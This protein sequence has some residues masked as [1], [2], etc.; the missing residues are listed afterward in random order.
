MPTYIRVKDLPNSA[1]SLNADDYIMLSGSVGGARKILK[2]DFLNTV[3]DEFEASP[4]TYKLATLD[5]SNKLN[6]EQL[7]ASAFSYQGTWAASTNTPTLANG[8][9]TAGHVYYASDSGS[10]NFGAGSI[11]FSTGDAVVYDGSIWQKVPDV[12]NI[13][14]GKGTVDEGKTTLEIPNVGTAANEVPTNGQLGDLAFQSSA[15]V[16]VDDLTVD[17]QLTAAVGKPMPVNGPTM[18]FD[19]VNDY[20]EF[21]DNDAFSFTNGTDDTPF[22]VS[23]WVKMEDATNFPV[24]SKYNTTTATREWLFYVSG[25]DYLGSVLMGSDGNAASVVSDEVITNRE[26]KW[27]HLAMTYAG[28]GPNS[29]NS[30]SSASASGNFE[31]YI[32]GKLQSNVTRSSAS[33]V[34]MQSTSQ[35]VELAR[36]NNGTEAKGE[37]RDVKLFNKELSAAEVREVYSNG[38][39]PESFAESTG[40][41]EIYTGDSSNFAGGIGNWTEEGSTSL[42]VAASG[43]E[44]LITNTAGASGGTKGARNLTD[45]VTEGKKLRLRFTARCSSGTAAGMTVKMFNG[46]TA[47]SAIK[48]QGSGTASSGSSAV[49]S[50]TPTG[51]NETHIVEFVLAGSA[52][53]KL[54]FNIS[55][56][57]TGEVYNF[58]NITLTQI[59]SVLDARAENYNQ[60]A[61]KLLDVSGNDFVGTQSGGV[62]LLTPRSHLSAGTLDLTN[63]PTSATGLSAGEVYNSSGTLK[64]V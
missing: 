47:T 22:S 23:A 28:A 44:M 25:S 40:G 37:I 20:I 11:S 36:F 12:A 60:S 41:A 5:A 52:T 63:L 62:E 43:G 55:A 46:S 61:G 14:D 38:Q 51:S 45:N 26:D 4:S 13:L 50:F 8:S 27:T 2:S 3:A 64:I 56:D 58:D 17:G 48:I 15:G 32:N 31:L 34:G 7:P 54:Y 39:L 18:R 21:A 49:Y 59:G 24:L 30:F 57:G 53:D 6:I 42:T 35:P 19:G 9:G 29:S 33:Y 16:V 10:V 1:S